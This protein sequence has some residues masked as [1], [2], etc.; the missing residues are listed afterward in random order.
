ML[1]DWP[2]A[3]PQPAGI[4]PDKVRTNPQGTDATNKPAS[5]ADAGLSFYQEESP[6]SLQDRLHGFVVTK[7][8]KL[9]FWCYPNHPTFFVP[10]IKDTVPDNIVVEGPDAVEKYV[11]SRIVSAIDAVQKEHVDRRR[12][13]DAVRI[14]LEFV[15]GLIPLRGVL[16]S[17][18]YGGQAVWDVHLTEPLG[19]E[20][21]DTLCCRKY[22]A[23]T[24]DNELLARD[25]QPT[26]YALSLAKRKLVELYQKR[27]HE[28][29][30]PV[31]Y[32]VL[33]RLKLKGHEPV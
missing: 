29:T 14:E 15:H 22:P 25:C 26:L 9:N 10:E 17:S 18:I 8:G 16:T 2:D 32:D 4:Q 28:K 7:D 13:L 19:Y 5:L 31:A 11:E 1:R 23:R 33:R 6:M 21:R 27:K 20:G 3:P 30:Y 24:P 12:K